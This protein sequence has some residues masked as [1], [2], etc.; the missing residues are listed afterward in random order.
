MSQYK[1]AR[2]I[3][4]YLSMPTGEILTTA[5]VEVA[6]AQDKE[7]FVPYIY[8]LPRGPH[9]AKPRKLMEMVSLHSSED[10]NS[11]EGHRDAW[12]IPLVN[13]GSVAERRR[14]LYNKADEAEQGE[15]RLTDERGVRRANSDL[16]MIVMPGVAFDRDCGR[17]GHGKG[18]YDFFLKRY[19]DEKIRTAG[20][21][22][23]PPHNQ[24][25]PFLGTFF[26]CSSES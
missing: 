26:G 9:N 6:L 22:N 21:D 25:M 18:F 1:A 15:E 20:P 24:R 23:H 16:D 3:G 7:V 5:V 8:E 17:V 10:F 12:G 19:H 14:I 4:I 13:S 11:I 2:S